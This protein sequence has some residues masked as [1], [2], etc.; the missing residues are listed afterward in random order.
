MKLAL[1]IDVD[2]LRGTREGTPNLVELLRRH[3][4]GATFAFAVGPDLTGRAALRLVGEGL[5]AHYGL[6]ALLYGTLLPPPDIGR[7]AGEL[8]RR[9]RDAG[10]D[11]GLHGWAPV[12]WQAR[13][14]G[15]A[16]AWTEAEMQRAVDRYAEVL[17]ERPAMHA[18]AGWQMNAH[19]LRMTQRLGFGYASDGRGTH[20]HLPV[21]RGELIRCPQF[22]TTL[23]TLPELLAQDGVSLDNV[24]AH[25][26]ERTA[27]PPACGHVFTLRAELEGLRLAPVLEQLLVGWK[28]QGY[29]L[30]PLR[31]LVDA[32]EPLALPR[33][34]VGFGT[35]PGRTGNVLLQGGEFLAD[36]DLARAA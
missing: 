24:A 1:K 13:A 5:A 19:A 32:V 29:E 23:P 8:M 3:G 36:V 16:A 22:P 30:V 10:F 25:L 4:A 2:T 26:L 31:T 18:A 14:A 7:R 11:T 27:A 20:P 35:L 33:C 15:A 21:W 28:A 34:E 17:G 12:R 9:V 6:R